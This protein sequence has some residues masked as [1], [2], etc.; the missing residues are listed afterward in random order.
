MP[1]G[2]R[3]YSSEEMRQILLRA[4][5][6]EVADEGCAPGA[7]EGLTR[8]EL[9]ET[10]REVGFSP[11]QI[12]AA[13]VQHEEDHQIRQ[14]QREL[15]QISQRRFGAHLIY[16][17]LVNGVMAAGNLWLGPPYWCLIP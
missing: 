15:R 10:A 11:E 3:R 13:L 14:V 16:F 17:L 6:A 4:Q 1:T 9:I 8:T 2:E 12:S 7:G 5:R